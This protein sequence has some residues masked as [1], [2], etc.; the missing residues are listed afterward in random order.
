MKLVSYNVATTLGNFT[1]IG[2]L[3]ENNV[4]DLN[5][6][7]V[8]YLNEGGIT[9]RPYETAA[10]LLPP[11]MEQ[12]LKGGR[13]TKETAQLVIDYA[14]SH[15]GQREAFRGPQGE[16]I[17]YKI[18]DVRLLA[19]IPRP[20]SLRDTLSFEGHMKAR[21]RRTGKPTPDLW[22][23]IPAYSKRDPCNVIG[24]N[25]LII[26][27][28]YTEKL[29]YELEFGVY[30]GKEGKDIS[31]D[32][33]QEYIAGYTIFN[34]VSARDVQKEEVT[35]FMGSMK[36]KDFDSSKPMGPCLVTPDELD[37]SDL[38]MI[39]RINGEVWSEGNSSDMYW[40]FNKI[41]EYISASETLFPGDFIAS[42]TIENGC[43]D[44]MERWI[45]PGDII[46]LEVEGIGVLRN[47][48][49]KEEDK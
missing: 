18:E 48:V 30:I 35:L 15:L 9:G 29:D 31:A 43:G 21:E 44:E 4:V 37:I 40:S 1:R 12:F 46:E 11:D 36:G 16:S 8:K 24:P 38:K 22:Y 7:Y 47:Q 25:E 5:L 33:A 2:V 49:V 28:K 32:K 42:G 3:V 20:N 27:P 17:I 13:L 34:D 14:H 26:W 39:A 23:K 10:A 45:K 19:P 41:I 6:A